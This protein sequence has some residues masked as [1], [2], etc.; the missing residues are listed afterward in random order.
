MSEPSLFDQL[1]QGPE[2]ECEYTPSQWTAVEECDRHLLV[3]AGAGTGKT[4]TVIGKLLWLLGVPMVDPSGELREHG[5]P[6]RLRDLAAITFTNQ[7]AADLKRKLRKR[8]REHGQRDLAHAVD[9]ARVGT[10]HSFCG[11]VLRE[12]ALRG[13]APLGGQVLEEGE[14]AALVAECA[15]DVLLAALDA[16]KVA[17]LEFLLRDYTARTVEEWIGSLAGD[18]DRLRRLSASHD[19]SDPRESALLHLAAS[20]VTRLYQRLDERGAVNF[21]RMIVAT[22]DLIRDDVGV[23]RALQRRIRVLVMDEFQDVDPV[24]REIAYLLGGVEEEV[25]DATRLMLVGDPK[26]SIY[27][28]RRADVSVWNEVQH[29]F[30]H[31]GRGS[32]ISLGENFRSVAPVLAFVEDCIGPVLDSPVGGESEA[33]HPFEVPFAPVHV[34]RNDQPAHAGVEFLVV[35]PDDEGNAR[36]VADARAMEAASVAERMMRLNRDNGLPWSE[37]AILLGGWRSLPIYENALRSRGIPTYALRNGGFH[38]TREIVDMQ[39]ALQI[40]RDPGDDRA[41]TGFLRSPFVGVKDETLLRI[42]RQCRRPFWSDLDNCSIA[43]AD[44]R[45][46]LERGRALITRLAALRD[47]IPAA[48]LLDELLLETG[49]LA[50][51][52]LRGD[53]SAQAAANVRQFLTDLRRRPEASVGTLLREIAESRAR[54]D[55]VQQAR[56]YGEHENVVTITSVHSSKGLEWGVVFWCDLMHAGHN[57]SAKLLTGSDELSL[58]DPDAD[59]KEQPDR[60]MK[61]QAV[62]KLERTAEQRRLWYVAATRARDLLVVSGIAPGK[63]A[64][65]AGTA[66]QM[67]MGRYGVLNDGAD[68][69]IAIS[70]QGVTVSAPVRVAGVAEADTDVSANGLEAA[71]AVA[72]AASLRMPP[73]PISVPAG[74]GRHSATSLMAHASCPRRHWF[75]YVL[76]APEPN[77]SRAVALPVAPAGPPPAGPTTVSPADAAAAR[78]APG[79]VSASHGQIVH[80]VLERLEEEAELELLLESAIA[81]RDIDAPAA[82]TEAGARYRERLAGEI[83]RVAGDPAYA[84][85]ATL[86]TARRE[87]DFVHLLSETAQVSGSMDLA[88]MEDG[89]LVILDVKTSQVSDRAEAEAVARR[90][91]VQRDVYRSAAAAISGLP[92][93]RFVFQFAHGGIQVDGADCGAGEVELAEVMSGMELGEPALA[94]D[95]RECLGCGYRMAGWCPGAEG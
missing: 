14:S 66:A 76:G 77:A 67:L 21:D 82:G 94:A 31:G 75:R 39:L 15:R 85:I 44:E 28:F 30:E 54:K 71:A 87:L 43:D 23:R 36:R 10:I 78:G 95:P 86:P 48:Q 19:G 53:D 64:R 3:S 69:E 12:F 46:L 63:G 47:R 60:W 2:R 11:D 29:A 68:G 5:N 45:D 4:H 72:P 55:D 56:L 26:Q 35:A 40:A 81:E 80:D 25:G 59:S 18:A 33:R 61:L 90:Y 92:V 52:A 57:G 74:L 9:A 58:G 79:G 8:L 88:A 22:R 13:N 6:I 41:L 91:A 70:G 51:L 16:G 37:M 42:A 89:G 20:T 34:T 1:P 27:R 17:G 83:R 7:A 84:A 50:H 38:D 65:L 93:S 49:Y 24:Q 32:V 73:A 62:L